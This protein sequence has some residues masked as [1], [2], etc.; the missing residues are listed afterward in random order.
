MPN[1]TLAQ[2]LAFEDQFDACLTATL[3][4]LLLP[5]NVPLVTYQSAQSALC[6]RLQARFEMEGQEVDRGA[7]HAVSGNRT[8]AS[9]RSG[10][11]TFDL[12]TRRTLGETPQVTLGLLRYWLMPTV[13]NLNANL[14]WLQ[15]IA[16]DEIGTKR[17]TWNEG[18]EKADISSIHYRIIFGVQPQYQSILG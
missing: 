13:S 7:I 11:F 12:V 3:A 15:I 14:A 8:T 1:P 9:A 16:M 17:G 10:N 4:P 2:L 18:Q 5:F 6:P